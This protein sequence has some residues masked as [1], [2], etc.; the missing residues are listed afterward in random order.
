MVIQEKIRSNV[1]MSAHPMGMKKYLEDNLNIASKLAKFNAPK[2]VLI[3]G[4]SSGYGLALRL[5]LAENG[6]NI[7]NVSFERAYD[8]KKSGSAG[9]W[10]NHFYQKH[11]PNHIDINADAFSIETKNQVIEYCKNNDIKIDLL[12][13]SLATGVRPKDDLIVKSALKP[14]G[15]KYTGRTIDLATK[16]FKDL[17]LEPANQQEIDDTIYVMG[18][19]DWYD[20]TELLHQ[21]QVLNTDFKTFSLTYI[22]GETTYDI[23][24]GGTIGKAKDDLEATVLELNKLDN[25]TAYVVSAKAITTKASVFIPSMVI[26]ASC[27]YDVMKLH[28]CH[29]NVVEHMHRLLKDMLYGENMITDELKRVRVDNLEMQENIQTETIN[30]MKT[31]SN[32]EILN[33]TGYQLF[34]TEFYQMNG[35]KY[36]DID[37]SQDLDLNSL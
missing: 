20:W 16:S 35:F 22:G 2:N 5:L 7:I 31:Y 36:N 24:R 14:I 8:E 19:S 28:Q 1:A 27:L 29:E 10:N 21:N 34:E 26:Y 17:D 9:Y 33:S 11:Y 23:Y 6:S 25:V 3:L 12:V 4:G 18:G 15:K 32:E 37:Y 13:Y 30:R